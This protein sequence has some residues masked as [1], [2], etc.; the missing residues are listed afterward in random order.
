MDLL[1]VGIAAGIAYWAYNNYGPTGVVIENSDQVYDLRALRRQLET[2]LRASLAENDALTSAALV[3][4]IEKLDQEAAAWKALVASAGDEYSQELDELSTYF[5]EA[6]TENQTLQELQMLHG[7]NAAQLEAEAARLIEISYEVDT[8]LAQR[9]LA[10]SSLALAVDNLDAAAIATQEATIASIDM[11]FTAL[12]NEVNGFLYANKSDM[13][14]LMVSYM[15]RATAQDEYIQQLKDALVGNPWREYPTLSMD[16]EMLPIPRS[17]SGDII[18]D[19]FNVIPAY[20]MLSGDIEH[21]R[22]QTQINPVFY[23]D[24]VG[25][26]GSITLGVEASGFYYTGLELADSF[27]GV[28]VA[29]SSISSVEAVAA[30]RRDTLLHEGGSEVIE[31][32]G[33]IYSDREKY[34]IVAATHPTL[35]SDVPD[36]YPEW[37]AHHYHGWTNFGEWWWQ[38][39][40]RLIQSVDIS[41]KSTASIVKLRSNLFLLTPNIL[42][43]KMINFTAENFEGAVF[44]KRK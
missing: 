34:D 42:Q 37:Y 28:L 5:T 29:A 9:K 24:G 1:K 14:A 44:L 23:P 4:E 43:T 12:Q 30:F 7:G 26:T 17:A 31:I 13:L 19:E 38:N 6:A 41:L 2:D 21:W 3:A 18:S 33:C 20:S 27:D 40:V 25:T 8:L 39:F 35:I 16:N 36:R 15:Q 11:Q 22:S 32:Q 10:E